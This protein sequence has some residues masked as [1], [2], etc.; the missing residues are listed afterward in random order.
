MTKRLYETAH[1]LIYDPVVANGN[2]TRSSLHSLGFR[3]VEL[4]P[5][6]DIL[7][8][9]LRARSPDL[10]LCE[11]SGAEA[12]LCRLIQRV[13]QGLLGHNPFIL[14]VVTTWRRDGT[15][16]SQVL[17]SGADDLVARPIS[18][19]MLGERIKVL[20]ERRKRF[21]VTYDYI[22]PDRRRDPD[23]PGAEC[24]DVP[25]SLQMRNLDLHAHEDG[26]RHIVDAILEGKKR[27]N[28]VKI[29]RDTVQLCMQWGLA[30]SRGPQTR[31]FA[32]ILVRME[33]NAEGIKRRAPEAD[34]EEAVEWC[35]SIIE[36][37]RRISAQTRSGEGAEGQ[38]A[39]VISPETIGPQLRLIGHATMALQRMLAPG[40]TA[41]PRLVDVEGRIFP[42]GRQTAAA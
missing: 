30:E 23:R 14:L 7:E 16:I 28:V 18:T 42:S 5:A 20:T 10:V 13:R 9:R 19:T 37:V 24:I 26:E 31:E 17:N 38:A 41:L 39:E 11:A 35:E 32:D 27:L 4:A 36:S 25:N 6:F 15:I 40:E 12:E 34:Y 22:G 3:N 2:S 33:R 1:T 8:N 29:Q 21:A